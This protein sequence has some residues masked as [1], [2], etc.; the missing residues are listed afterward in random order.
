M[1]LQSMRFPSCEW[2][3]AGDDDLVQRVVAR[4]QSRLGS[5][6]RNFDIEVQCSDRA[7]DG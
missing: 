6:V 4:L 3:L 1:H 5:Q 2:T 7:R